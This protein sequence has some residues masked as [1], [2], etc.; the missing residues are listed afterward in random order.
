MNKAQEVV[1]TAAICC[2]VREKTCGRNVGDG[3]MWRDDLAYQPVAW[4]KGPTRFAP[5]RHP[6]APMSSHALLLK[7]NSKF[8]NL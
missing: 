4:V 7:P 6:R 5:L 1:D 2:Y 8:T 3:L